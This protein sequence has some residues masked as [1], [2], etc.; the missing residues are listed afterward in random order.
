LLNW[1]NRE[2]LAIIKLGEALANGGDKLQFSR[3]ILK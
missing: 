2:A 1:L 3:N